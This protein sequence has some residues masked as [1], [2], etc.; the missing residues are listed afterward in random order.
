MCKSKCYCYWCL[1]PLTAIGKQRK[2]G[3]TFASY[4]NGSNDWKNRKYHKKC[5]KER[6][7]YMMMCYDF[8][9]IDNYRLRLKNKEKKL[10]EMLQEKNITKLN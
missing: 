3:K 6:S 4:K 2:N 10:N 7:S 8:D 1:K 9:D 5:D